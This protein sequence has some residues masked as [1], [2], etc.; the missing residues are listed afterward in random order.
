MQ[1]PA[2]SNLNFEA[3]VNH[4]KQLNKLYKP[5]LFN[6]KNST[7][8]QDLADLL[9]NNAHI[10]IFD[11][12]QSQIEELIKCLKPGINP[13]DVK[14]IAENH[15]GAILPEDYGKTGTPS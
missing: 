12:I 11:R 8:K 10:Q 5:I 4:T 13:A 2:Y 6:T 15:R 14:T 1:S 7:E 3:L 9:M